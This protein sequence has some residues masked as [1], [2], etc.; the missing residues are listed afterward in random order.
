MIAA[1]HFNKKYYHDKGIGYDENT[2]FYSK[3]NWDELASGLKNTYKTILNKRLNSF[4]D[5]GCA[6]GY[7]VNEMIK[8]G[9]NAKGIDI[10]KFA[11]SEAPQEVKPFIRCGSLTDC[12]IGKVD[13]V[14]AYG[15]LHYLN[16]KELTAFIKKC[17]KVSVLNIGQFPL[18]DDKE[19]IR[20]WHK[21]DKIPKLCKRFDW[22]C[23][24]IMKEGWV[25]DTLKYPD[26]DI[27][28]YFVNRN[29]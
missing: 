1:R 16:E 3:V 14:R 15:T 22:W 20:L 19:T 24:L 7:L 2:S 26:G 23:N 29:S 11:I 12:R 8:K 21:L 28:C 25:L 9:V 13:M 18:G 4:F 5:A 10:S 17:S 6:K 27:D